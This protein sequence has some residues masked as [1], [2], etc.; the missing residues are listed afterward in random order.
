MI[1]V[2][3]DDM[4]ESQYL[5]VTS[6]MYKDATRMN[7]E[8]VDWLLELQELLNDKNLLPNGQL[9]IYTRIKRGDQSFRA[10]PNYRGLG[11]WR[12]WA[13]FQYERIGKFLMHMWCFVV[14][15]DMKGKRLDYGGIRLKEGV[16]AAAEGS[17]MV[18]AERNFQSMDLIKLI[19]KVVVIGHEQNIF[20]KK[21]ELA[22]TD[23]IVAPACVVPNI[24]GPKHQY[25]FIDP[26]E[27]W[28]GHFLNWLRYDFDDDDMVITDDE[29]EDAKEAQQLE[30]E[31]EG[32]ADDQSGD[33]IS[34]AT[35]RSS[36]TD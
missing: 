36:D 14:I 17:K 27:N 13:W 12:D 32:H 6:S 15:P 2:F 35:T 18:A 22:D 31:E 11:P 34:V 3:R 29:E 19:E 4:G 24:G 26:R 23:A 33:E 16:Y 5:M 7:G 25:F 9:L 1:Q 30:Q 20:E 28:A 8:L 21:F 10:H